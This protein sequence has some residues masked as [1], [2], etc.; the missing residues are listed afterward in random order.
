MTRTLSAAALAA[1]FALAGVA[2]A[3]AWERKSTV[4]GPRGTNSLTANG[5]CGS[6]ACTRDATAT[7][8]GGRTFTR[9]GDASC[10][11]GNCSGSRTTTGPA[12]RAVN[13][14]FSLTR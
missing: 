10:A 7:G 12:G 11:D 5:D 8:A 6:R 1:A 4:N 9:K 3:H 13:R 14:T 2:D